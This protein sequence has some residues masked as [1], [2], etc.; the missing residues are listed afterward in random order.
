[1]PFVTAAT[2]DFSLLMPWLLNFA[3]SK[4]ITFF[5]IMLIYEK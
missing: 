1:M 4:T 5:F 2:A 3:K